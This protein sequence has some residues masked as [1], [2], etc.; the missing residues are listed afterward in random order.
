MD[1]RTSYFTTACSNCGFMQVMLTRTDGEKSPFITKYELFKEGA[2]RATFT[3]IC[4]STK[5]HSSLLHH[6]ETSDGATTNHI[7][8]VTVVQQSDHSVDYCLKVLPERIAL[9][10]QAALIRINDVMTDL[11]WLQSFTSVS[12]LTSRFVIVGS[13]PRNPDPQR[14]LPKP[15]LLSMWESSRPLSSR[16]SSN[17]L[18]E[19]LL[20]FLIGT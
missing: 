18:T 16:L 8:S 1:Y 17:S 3:D 15:S 19:Q 7:K 2:F 9:V 10:W 12:T 11:I 20:F 14:L 13:R 6:L 4:S 5:T